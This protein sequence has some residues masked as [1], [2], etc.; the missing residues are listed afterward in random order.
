[1]LVYEEN[2][3]KRK[4]M[5][6]NEAVIRA[7]V[8]N[9]KSSTMMENLENAAMAQKNFVMVPFDESVTEEMKD[10]EFMQRIVQ[11]SEEIKKKGRP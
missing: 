2:H 1:M 6:E 7:M 11:R 4:D 5:S 8:E 3:A 9:A 10:Q